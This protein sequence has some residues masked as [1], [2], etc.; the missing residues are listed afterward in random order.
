MWKNALSRN[1]EES[2]KKFHDPDPEGKDFLNL[3]SSALSTDTCVVKFSRRCVQ[4]FLR[5][6]VN[7][8]TDRQTNAGHY[9]TVLADVVTDT[10]T[11]T[12]QECILRRYDEQ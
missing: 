8:Q 11:F 1:V 5:E 6:A 10:A 9:I 7:R 2:F 12:L 4:Q 3:I